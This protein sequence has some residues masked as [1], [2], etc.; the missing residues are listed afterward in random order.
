M[1]FVA[2]VLL[3][4][5]TTAIEYEGEPGDRKFHL[6]QITWIRNNCISYIRFRLIYLKSSM[7]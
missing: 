7:G 1:V 2:F 3:P 4:S 6:N 5:V